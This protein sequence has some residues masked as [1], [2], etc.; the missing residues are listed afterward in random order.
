MIA[1]WVVQPGCDV[2]VGLIYL[3]NGAH[4]G[5]ILDTLTHTEDLAAKIK[6]GVGLNMAMLAFNGPAFSLPALV[7]CGR[8]PTRREPYAS[9]RRILAGNAQCIYHL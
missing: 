6:G 2:R 7:T 8:T 3:L 1:G 5:V 9:A 4:A